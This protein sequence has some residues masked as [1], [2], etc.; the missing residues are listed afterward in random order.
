MSEQFLW[1]N[2]IL[3]V[4]DVVE[5]ATF[6]EDKLGFTVNILWQ[7][8]SYAVV[9]RGNATIEFGEGR[10]QHAGSGIC[11]IGIDDADVIYE[12]WQSKGIEFVGD[13]AERDYSSKDF[14]VRDN[15]G[16]MLIVGHALKNQKELL[17][18]GNIA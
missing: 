11:V 4:K 12:E 7:N 5:T 18:K 1:A 16:N 2:P 15:N 13:F 8:P 10:K 14:R 17:Q 6:F 3:P 9:N